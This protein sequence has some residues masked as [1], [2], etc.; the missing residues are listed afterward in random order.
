MRVAGRPV[1]GLGMPR[2]IGRRWRRPR[3]VR[4]RVRARM[5][6]DLPE[7]TRSRRSGSPSSPSWIRADSDR[8]WV[9]ARQNG[10]ANL[11]GLQRMLSPWPAASS[12]KFRQRSAPSDGARRAGG[13]ALGYV[14]RRVLG[15]YDAFLPPDD[16]G[17]LYFVGPNVAEVEQRFLLPPRDFRLDRRPRGDPSRA[18]RVG[19]VA[20]DHIRGQVDRYLGTVSLES[21]DL[22][23]RRYAGR[24]TRRAPAPTSAGWAGCSSC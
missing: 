8:A 11:N 5:R 23:K 24:S 14:S 15:Q 3:R 9:M 6:E 10:C 22:G 19:A 2:S 13:C 18:V 1:G 21:N 12:R 16:E 20:R 17:L 7:L 4:S